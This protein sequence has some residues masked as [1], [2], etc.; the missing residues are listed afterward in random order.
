[1]LNQAGLSTTLPY[2]DDLTAC[3]VTSGAS[4]HSPLWREADELSRHMLRSWPRDSWLEED[5]TDVSRMLDMQVRLGNVECIDA[6]LGSVPAQGRY[7]ASD[8]EAILRAAALLPT[9]RATELL[10]RILRRNALSHLA[11]CGG[12]LLHCVAAP[13]GT[14]CDLMQIG[15]ALIEALPG[16]PTERQ[17]TDP[18]ARPVSVKPG[19]VVDLL[20]ATSR[21][22]AALASRAIEHLLAWPRTYKPDEVLV[23]AASAFA[24]LAE[25]PAWPAVVRLREACLDHL[26]RRIAQ[27]LEARRDCARSNLLKCTCGDCRGLGTFLVAPDQQQWRLKAVQ[28][29]RSHVEQSVRS[30]ACDLDLTT[31]SATAPTR[32]LPRRTRP[33]TNGAQGSAGR[34]WRMCRHWA[35]EGRLASHEIARSTTG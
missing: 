22:D 24:K 17:E 33:A 14:A 15:A 13:A 2:L 10:V 28:E 21:I 20:T 5:D 18:W 9:S 4:I 1:V 31:E 29:R 16:P 27:P 23:P 7:A 34:I 11:T 12:L 25:S 6:F 3:W 30:A 32:W 26:R 8:N 19:F 35:D